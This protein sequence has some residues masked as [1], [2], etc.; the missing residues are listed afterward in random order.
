MFLS[1]SV[2][3]SGTGSTESAPSS[4]QDLMKGVE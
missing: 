4:V 1:D 2:R 3:L